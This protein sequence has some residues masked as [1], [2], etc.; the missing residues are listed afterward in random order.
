[1]VDKPKTKKDTLFILNNKF[2]PEIIKNW[3]ILITIAV[4]FFV[5]GQVLLKSVHKISAY[6]ILLLWSMSM[7]LVA[8]LFFIYTYRSKSASILYEKIINYPIIILSGILFFAGNAYF[9]SGLR[10]ADNL[11][12]LWAYMSGLEIASLILISWLLWNTQITYYELTG[13]IFI[14]IGLSILAYKKDTAKK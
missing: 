10:K 1:M 7:G 3:T 14:G 13:I 6:D 4:V 9:I 5:G 2:S 8:F 12:I 11:G